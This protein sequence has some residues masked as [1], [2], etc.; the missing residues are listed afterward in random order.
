LDIFRR[1]IK[2]DLEVEQFP[3]WT[4]TLISIVAGQVCT[5][6]RSVPYP[7]QNE[8]SFVL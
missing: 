7:L 1:L 4:T 2:L 8:L 6:T 5:L 3:W